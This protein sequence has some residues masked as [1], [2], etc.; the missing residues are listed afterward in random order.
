M[1]HPYILGI[2]TSCDETSIA[3]VSNTKVLS[4][5][6]ASQIKQ[7]EAFGGVFPE[8]ASRLHTENIG[9]VLQTAIKESNISLKSISAIAVTRGPG[10]IG[11]LHIGL[12]TAKVLAASLNIP[13]IGVHHHAAHLEAARFIQ[14]ILYPALGLIVSGGHTELVYMPGPL[15]YELIGQTQDDAIGESYDK[16]ARMMGL[17]Y[18]GG[19]I[20]DQLAQ[21]GTSQYKLP[22]PKATGAFDFSYSGLKTAVQSLIQKEHQAKRVI[23][24]HNL[25]FDFQKLVIQ[26]LI[27]KLQL[28]LKTYPVKSVI[29]G[30]GVSLNRELRKQANQLSQQTNIPF[31]FPPTWA[32]TDN[33]AMIALLGGEMLKAGMID[34]LSLGVDPSWEIQASS[35]K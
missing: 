27:D 24:Q 2:E 28:A 4:H 6:T 22:L 14:P 9:Y 17:G 32:C 23:N 19:P 3:V 15:R 1:T 29:I 26:T 21:S 7:H 34:S 12:Q 8:L 16:V 20:I 10:L 30:G 18:P 35:Q 33:G 13:L 25:A 5:V 11:A 31:I